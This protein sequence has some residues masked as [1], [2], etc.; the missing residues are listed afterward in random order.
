MIIAENSYVLFG[1]LLFLFHDLSVCCFCPLSKWLI[2]F[3]KRITGSGTA[4]WLCYV[5]KTF[6]RECISSF[7]FVSAVSSYHNLLS[8]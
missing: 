3:L 7:Q 6:V 4:M 2:G 8:G 5:Q 1:K